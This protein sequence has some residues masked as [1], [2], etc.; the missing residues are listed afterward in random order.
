MIIEQELRT[1]LDVWAP[2]LLKV[3][4]KQAPSPREAVEASREARHSDAAMC[5]IAKIS[6]DSRE[7]GEMTPL[8]ED[9]GPLEL[10]KRRS[11]SKKRSGS[12]LQE[13]MPQQSPESA[14]PWA[15]L[16]SKW[17]DAGRR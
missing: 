6:I 12:F 15:A 4:E 9:S 14:A 3:P 1:V 10:S 8:R 13:V 16:S 17:A 2:H 5:D 7:L 11:A